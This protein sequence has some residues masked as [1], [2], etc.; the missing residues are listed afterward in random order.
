M[1]RFIFIDL[2]IC[3][4]FALFAYSNEVN[5]VNLVRRVSGQYSGPA[6]AVSTAH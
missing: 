6:R 5:A 4:M 2:F 1:V 3:L